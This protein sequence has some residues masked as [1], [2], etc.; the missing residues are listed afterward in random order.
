MSTLSLASP[1][2]EA[3]EILDVCTA[4]KL[5]DRRRALLT[6]IVASS[7]SLLASPEKSADTILRLVMRMRSSGID[8]QTLYD[9]T[10]AATMAT[11][12]SFEAPGAQ[13]ATIV[14]TMANLELEV[15]RAFERPQRI[16]S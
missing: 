14:A 13:H 8:D 4:T 2:V 6:S 5:D 9:L 16:A 7:L 1:L 3:I 10:F 12:S 15:G 11:A